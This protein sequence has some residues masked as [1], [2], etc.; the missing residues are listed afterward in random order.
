[1]KVHG[2]TMYQKEKEILYLIMDNIF[3]DNLLMGKLME[4]EYLFII[5]E[6]LMKEMYMK[7]KQM[8]MENMLEKNFNLKVF[9]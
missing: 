4:K 6:I 3:K 9:G 1:M 5:M 2:K 7:I 8:D